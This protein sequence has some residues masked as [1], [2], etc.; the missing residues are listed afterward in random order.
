MDFQ[1]GLW[2]TKFNTTLFDTLN[3]SFDD[4]YKL[5]VDKNIQDQ[6]K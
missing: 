3:I 2:I 5:E 1:S 4:I 6:N